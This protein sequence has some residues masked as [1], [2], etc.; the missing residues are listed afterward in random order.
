MFIRRTLALGLAILWLWPAG[1]YAQSE[2]LM[3]TYRQGQALE[4]AGRYEQAISFYREA[5]ELGEREFGPNDPTTATL[6]TNLARLYRAQGRY[7]AAEPLYERALAIDEKALGP[8]HP[9]VAS[10]LNN[11]ATLYRAQGRYEA[12]DRSTNG[13]WRS[14]RR[15]SGRTIPRSPPASPTSPNFTVSRVATPRPRHSISER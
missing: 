2:V 3:E 4:K 11:L 15:R 10:S 8:E 6:L 12:G 5:L 9:D 13:R 1:L 14:R 7:E